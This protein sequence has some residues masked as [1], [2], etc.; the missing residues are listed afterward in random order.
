MWIVAAGAAL[1]I[2]FKV[3]SWWSARSLADKMA[4]AG[5]WTDG[6]ESTA[7]SVAT[8]AF[9]IARE[10]RW[11]LSVA[12]PIYRHLWDRVSAFQDPEMSLV[13]FLYFAVM[14]HR[15]G[16]DDIGGF[17]EDQV[18]AAAAEVRAADDEEIREALRQT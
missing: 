18:I 4:A 12:L 9:A 14:G 7:K 2:L 13:K 1:V 16:S 8:L 3:G 5:T 10:Q 6:F 11:R 15:W 17:S